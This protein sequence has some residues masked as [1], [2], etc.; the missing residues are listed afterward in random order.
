MAWL[1]ECDCQSYLYHP[2]ERPLFHAP[3]VLAQ[4][5]RLFCCHYH[6]VA[7]HQIFS[8]FLPNLSV[9]DLLF[10]EGEQAVAVI[11]QGM[12]MRESFAAK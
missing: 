8:G 12:S 10:N 9:L 3:M 2:K 7:Y 5:I 6:P 11:Q 4:G 1:K